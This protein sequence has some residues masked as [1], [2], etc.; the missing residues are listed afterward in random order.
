MKTTLCLLLL[1]LEQSTKHLLAKIVTASACQT[2]G[3][4]AN[5]ERREVVIIAV[6]ADGGGGGG[7]IFQSFF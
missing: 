1:E 5:K 6:S 7:P 2:E 4:K 3:G